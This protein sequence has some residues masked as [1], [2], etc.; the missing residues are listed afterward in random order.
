MESVMPLMLMM[1][2]E[3]A[4]AGQ[5]ELAVRLHGPEGELDQVEFVTYLLQS[6]VP[7]PLRHVRERSNG[8]RLGAIGRHVLGVQ[9][10]VHRR[11]GSEEVLEH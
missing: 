11:D 8:F 7:N 6:L 10:R 5:S 3:A 1:E 4:E 2:T 9:A